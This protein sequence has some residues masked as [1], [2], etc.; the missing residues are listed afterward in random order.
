VDSDNL[1][2]NTAWL[3]DLRPEIS[4][5]PDLV[6]YLE[7]ARMAKGPVLEL[8]CGTGRVTLPLAEAGYE[9]WGI[10]LSEEILGVLE[11]K[12]KTL[13]GE[14]DRRLHI[15]RAD[16]CDF[17]LNRKFALI[18]IPARSFGVLTTPQQQTDCLACVRK[19]LQPDGRFIMN[20]MRLRLPN[21]TA[22]PS[23]EEIPTGKVIDPETGR[24]IRRAL[25]PLP[26]GA[27]VDNQVIDHETVF[28][29]EQ[30]DGSEER[31]SDRITVALFT[32]QQ[33]RELLVSNGF[34]ILEEMRGFDGRPIVDDPR[35][36]DLI[37]VCRRAN[38]G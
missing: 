18:I 8:A 19:H 30:P 3:Y 25:L 15:S 22:S 12:R 9:V 17:D 14:A 34:E 31:I 28:Y 36:T 29:I 26:R 37:F 11:K 27:D 38:P 35:P 1:Y 10:D 4:G 16:M 32:E 20:V 7:R 5:L 33:M 13:P 6:F 23:P 24:R 2:H 21:G